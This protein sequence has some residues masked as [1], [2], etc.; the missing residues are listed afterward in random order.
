MFL[1]SKSAVSK[2]SIASN[3]KTHLTLTEFCNFIIE[4]N[5]QMQNQRVEPK[6]GLPMKEPRKERKRKL[7]D[8]KMVLTNTKPSLFYE[9]NLIQEA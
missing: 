4:Q 3:T 2:K 8:I 5:T 7:K 1:Q 9:S 6:S